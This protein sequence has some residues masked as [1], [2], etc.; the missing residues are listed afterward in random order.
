MARASKFSKLKYWIVQQ[1]VA[2]QL[3]SLQVQAVEAPAKDSNPNQNSPFKMLIN[4]CFN[5]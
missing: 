1:L 5:L 4:S 2:A 3:Y